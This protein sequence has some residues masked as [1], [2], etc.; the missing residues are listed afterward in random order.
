VATEF[1]SALY[2]S[3]GP[4]VRGG[5]LRGGRWELDL[6][7]GRELLRLHGLEYLPGL[8][9]TGTI[10]QF[11][12]RRPEGRLRVSGSAGS[13]GLVHWTPRLVEGELDGRPVRS[14]SRGAVATAS[15]AGAAGPTRAQVLR[16]GRRLAERRISAR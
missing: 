9:V 15:A 5:G 11:L 13:Q 12:S 7:R 10:G 1:F 3:S 8:R 14:Q 4:V 2:T 16:A 6:R